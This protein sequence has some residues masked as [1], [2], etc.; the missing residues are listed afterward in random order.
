MPVC[1]N[2]IAASPHHIIGIWR[3]LH[4]QS[5]YGSPLHCRSLA[6]LTQVVHI[7]AAV[8]RGA[9]LS[10]ASRSYLRGVTGS[11]SWNKLTRHGLALSRDACSGVIHIHD[12]GKA[13]L[14]QVRSPVHRHLLS[15]DVRVRGGMFE[16]VCAGWQYSHAMPMKGTEQ[17]CSS[18]TRIS[19]SC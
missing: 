6:A 17:T 15:S 10:Y 8:V 14:F 16:N 2:T 13:F 9:S 7:A 3:G 5:M 11:L 18:H 4:H 19:I 12:V 1:P